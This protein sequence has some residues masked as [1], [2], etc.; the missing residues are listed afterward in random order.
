MTL[1][2]DKG[3]DNTTNNVNF[4]AFFFSIVIKSFSTL[5]LVKKKRQKK[6]SVR[7]NK[8]PD[9]KYCNIV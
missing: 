9:M 4:I 3:Y 8:K 5:L 6:L 1:R 7:K 2:Q